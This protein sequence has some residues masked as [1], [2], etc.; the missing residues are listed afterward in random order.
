MIF[1]EQCL[2]CGQPEEVELLEVWASGEFLLSTCCEGLHES[3]VDE[4]NR[5]PDYRTW[6]LN[7][8]EAGPLLGG[9]KL[10]RVA[11]CDGQFLLDWNPDVRPI[12]QAEAKAFVNEHHAHNKAPAGWRYGCG[13]WNGNQLIGVCMVGRPVARAIDATQVVEVNRLCINR[14]IPRE[15][16]WN[17]C[18]LAYGWAARE[19]KRRGFAKIITYTL[20]EEL[21]TALKACGWIQ[22]ATTKGGSWNTPAR[23]R[24]D[25]APICRKVRW[26]RE[27]KGLTS[28]KG[29]RTMK[30]S[31]ATSIN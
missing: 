11:D 13:I 10:R 30:S 19:A 2:H 15:L 21:G 28:G 12:A 16:V 23:A 24:Q 31:P 7:A 14:G 8:L 5:D 29:A 20:E 1:H 27:F 22:E 4:M 26:A 3:I 6:L 25:K 18:S 9:H 17:A